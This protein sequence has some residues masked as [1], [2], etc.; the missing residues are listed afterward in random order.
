[1]KVLV[2]GS[3]DWDNVS[4]IEDELKKIKI[5]KLISGGAR[6][7]DKIAENYALKNSIQTEIYY[8]DW[9][10]Y[11]KYAGPKR[12][13]DMVKSIPDIILAFQ[14]DKS[15]GTQ[16]TIDLGRKYGIHIKIFEENKN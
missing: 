16:N 1:M 5:T 6:G 15:R 9:N 4:L 12:N 14:K 13:E 10:K 2:C 3:R 7:A 11:G 8:P